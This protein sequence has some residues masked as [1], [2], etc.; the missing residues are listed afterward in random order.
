MSPLPRLP[1]RAPW[2]RLTKRP[3]LHGFEK[4]DRRFDS[5]FSLLRVT[6]FSLSFPLACMRRIQYLMLASERS[7]EDNL[8]KNDRMSSLGVYFR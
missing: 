1:A 4:F 6:A 7:A 3:A 2:R 8:S 5:P